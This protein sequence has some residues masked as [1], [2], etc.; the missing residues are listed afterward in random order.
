MKGE[1]YMR[2]QYEYLNTTPYLYLSKEL[3]QMYNQSQS[4]REIRS[5]LNHMDNHKVANKKEYR[6]YFNLSQIIEEDLYGEEEE[7]LDFKELIDRYEIVATKSGV[8]FL[9][10]DEEEQP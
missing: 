3:R 10:K 9:E 1:G 6:G 5:I 8:K 7:I 4:R 2:W